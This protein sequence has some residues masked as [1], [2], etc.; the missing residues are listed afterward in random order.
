M[1]GCVGLVISSNIA[2]S[3]NVLCVHWSCSCKP[4]AGYFIR[5]GACVEGQI[6]EGVLMHVCFSGLNV[7]MILVGEA[8]LCGAVQVLKEEGHSLTDILTMTQ[9]LLESSSSL[10]FSLSLE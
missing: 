4:L 2:I 8:C 6:Y 1:T 3:R 10:S 9:S 5:V 7:N